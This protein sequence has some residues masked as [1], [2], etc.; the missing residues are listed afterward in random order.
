MRLQGSHL[1]IYM[2]ATTSMAKKP[3]LCSVEATTRILGGRKA[4]LL[5]QLFE[6]E[7]RFSELEQCVPGI[8]QL[9]RIGVHTMVGTES[10]VA[11][12]GYPDSPPRVAS[13]ITSRNSSL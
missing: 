8:T 11:R 10:F 4:A 12:R 7:K 3:A 1:E 5:E 6:G 2:R 9:P 13:S